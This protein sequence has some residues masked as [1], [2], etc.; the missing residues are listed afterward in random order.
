MFGYATPPSS[1][2]SVQPPSDIIQTPLI[3][4]NLL[5]SAVLRHEDRFEYPKQRA[6]AWVSVARDST[7][8]FVMER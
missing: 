4:P 2:P 5:A 3:Y 7:A 8:A 1:P 6:Q